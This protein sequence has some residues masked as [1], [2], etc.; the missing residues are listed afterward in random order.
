VTNILSGDFCVKFH[1]R[2]KDDGFEW[3]VVAV[4]G[5]V[6]DVNKPKFLAE[7]ARRKK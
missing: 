4:C 5:A 3:A 6:Q 1:L 2:N 7:L